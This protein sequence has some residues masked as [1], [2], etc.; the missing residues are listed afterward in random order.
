MNDRDFLS[1]MLRSV[2]LSGALFFE[3]DATAPWV[4][5]AP[6][7]DCIAPTVVSDAQ[8]VI[9]YHVVVEGN[10]WTRLTNPDSPPVALS[11]GSVVVF[12]H[13]D[14]HV[15]ASDP[16]LDAEPSLAAFDEVAR[17]RSLPFHIDHRGGEVGT[18]R[19]LC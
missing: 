8:H 10:C 1:E 18:A 2:R 13:G 12:P 6:P 16:V 15:L 5:A 17:G 3:V 9:E 14:T 4:A 11:P 7:K 19:I